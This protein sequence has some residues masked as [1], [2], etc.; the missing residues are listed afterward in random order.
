[1]SL[2]QMSL[3]QIS[4]DLTQMVNI[5]TWFPDCES[6]SPALWDL[7]LSSSVCICFTIAFSSFGISNHVVVSVSID[8]PSNGNV[9]FHSIAYEFSLVDWGW[10]L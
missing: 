1:M 3:S 10:S 2:S 8:F 9:P 7:F 6:R 5:P 4:N